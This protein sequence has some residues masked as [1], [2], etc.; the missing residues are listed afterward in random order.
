MPEEFHDTARA[1]AA[2]VARAMGTDAWPRLRPALLELLARHGTD[3]AAADWADGFADMIANARGAEQNSLRDAVYARCETTFTSLLAARPE[4]AGELAWLA[5]SGA[6]AGGPGSAPAAGPPAGTPG[7]PGAPNFA[8]PPEQVPAPGG[9]YGPPPVAAAPPVA[10]QPQFPPQPQPQPQPQFPSQPFAAPPPPP[11]PPGPPPGPAGYP[12]APGAFPQQPGP[13][14]AP[15]QP[16]GAYPSGPY[17]G[18]PGA[19]TGARNN[20]KLVLGGILAVAVIVGGVF[21]GIALF[22]GDDDDS[23]NASGPGATG[24]AKPGGSD[25]SGGEVEGPWI[26]TYSNQKPVKANGPVSVVLTQ[27][28]DEITG[29]LQLEAPGCDFT[30]PVTGKVKGSKITLESGPDTAYR[31]QMEGTVSGDRMS[32]SYTTTCENASGT[33][34]ADKG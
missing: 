28:G 6:S 2:N 18:A 13:Y 24:P 7:A 9:S 1:A 25:G 5:G 31:I 34:K 26:G 32:G 4:A 8:K 27:D 3:P 15:P 29:D 16:A 10:S 11:G 33:W 21:G 12:G 17:P 30:G 22:G 14:P 19:P 20:N 23:G